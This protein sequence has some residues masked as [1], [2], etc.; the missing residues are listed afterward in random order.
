MKK[1]ERMTKI[2]ILFIKLLLQ[3]ILESEKHHYLIIILSIIQ[4]NAPTITPFIVKKYV[5]FD[6]K[7]IIIHILDICGMECYA[8]IADI[9]YKDIK[10]TFVVYY[11]TDRQSFNSVCKWID[12]YL[13]L[14]Q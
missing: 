14:N 10:G 6:G 3:E 1:N 9:F 8:P 12:K 2:L 5:S 4:T 7:Y 11:I 13:N